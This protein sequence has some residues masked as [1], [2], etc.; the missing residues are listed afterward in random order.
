M[1]SVGLAVLFHTSKVDVEGAAGVDEL[2]ARSCGPGQV[3]ARERASSRCPQLPLVV[4]CCPGRGRVPSLSNA[5][6]SASSSINV[7]TIGE[8]ALRRRST[9]H[10]LAAGGPGLPCQATH[11]SST[12]CR[13]LAF[14]LAGGGFGRPAKRWN[15]T[16][17]FYC[18]LPDFRRRGDDLLIYYDSRQSHSVVIPKA[19]ARCFN[20]P[21][22]DGEQFPYIRNLLAVV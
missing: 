22:R 17:L 1:N 3:V 20:A 16:P 11:A 13:R 21:S 10:P 19:R 5:V 12:D 18:L 9:W 6:R 14:G 2:A 4:A 8:R 7:T 15:P